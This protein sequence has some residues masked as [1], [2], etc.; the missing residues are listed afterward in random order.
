MAPGVSRPGAP[1]VG[2][3]RMACRRAMEAYGVRA[4]PQARG[5][6]DQHQH[7]RRRNSAVYFNYFG[8]DEVQFK[9]SGTD[10]EM[11]TPGLHMVAV[12]KSGSNEFHGRYE[13]SYQGPKLQSNNLND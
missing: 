1:D 2:G 13:G 6:G 8:F 10:A 4:Q 3:S 9:T 7:R 5:R 11:G 12:L